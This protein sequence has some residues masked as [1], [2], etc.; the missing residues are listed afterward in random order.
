MLGTRCIKATG[1]V[2]SEQQPLLFQSNRGCCF[3]CFAELSTKNAKQQ[4]LLFQN[5]RDCCFKTTWVVVSKQQGL[6]SHVF[7][8]T[9]NDKYKQQGAV[10]QKYKHQGLLLQNNTGCCL[11][12]TAPV[13]VSKQQGLLFQNNRSCCL[14]I[15]GDVVSRPVYKIS[16]NVNS[17]Q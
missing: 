2:V 6:L 7:C 9:A 3:V 8:V 16:I 15:T 14:K 1:A 11:K 5:N 17:T 4:G 12:T 13:V 10:N